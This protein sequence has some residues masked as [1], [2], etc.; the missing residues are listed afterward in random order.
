MQADRDIYP[1]L[2]YSQVWAW[3]GLA[4]LAL[5]LVWYAYVFLRT[6]KPL[7]PQRA[8]RLT[9]PSDLAGLKEAYLQKIDAV[10]ADLEAGLL[11]ARESHQELSLLV[12]RFVLDAT[13][14]DAPRMTLAELHAHP[15]PAAAEAVRR[16]Y[17]GEFGAEPLPPV[18]E[19]AETAR[20]AVRQWK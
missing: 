7:R 14:V 16:I 15:L 3:T 1:P 18:D 5:V 12:R 8:P 19:S 17:P 20:R 6:R 11:S 4:L 9:P 2:H 10:R 13:G